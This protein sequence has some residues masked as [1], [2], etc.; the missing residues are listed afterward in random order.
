MSD[1]IRSFRA[2]SV[3]DALAQIRREM[4]H[5]AVVVETKQLTKRGL[6]SWFATQAEVEVTASVARSSRR[7]SRSSSFQSLSSPPLQQVTVSR[8]LVIQP[9]TQGTVAAAAAQAKRNAANGTTDVSGS[10]SLAVD[11]APTK[12]RNFPSGLLNANAPRPIA[13]VG[14]SGKEGPRGEIVSLV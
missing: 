9:T 7:S 10:T 14:T 12:I 6:F 3:E 8:P 4:G 11:D 1:N 13:E 5:E 2:A